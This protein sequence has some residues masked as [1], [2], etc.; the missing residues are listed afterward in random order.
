MIDIKHTRKW[1]YNETW[2]LKSKSNPIS[3]FS[4]SQTLKNKSTIK[5]ESNETFNRET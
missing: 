4:K 1:L 5:T 3:N 2:N